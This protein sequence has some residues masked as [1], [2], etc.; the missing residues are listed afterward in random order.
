MMM[1]NVCFECDKEIDY[2]DDVCP[3]CGA[4]Q[5][6]DNPP[7]EKIGFKSRAEVTKM[8]ARIGGTSEKVEANN[9]AAMTI[10]NCYWLENG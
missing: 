1:K 3:F 9:P 8:L 10:L 6:S 7:A 2:M 5:Y 4:E